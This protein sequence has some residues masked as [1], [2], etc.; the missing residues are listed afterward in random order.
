MLSKHR[1]AIGVMAESLPVPVRVFV[2]E[3]FA[4]RSEAYL[5][6]QEFQCYLVKA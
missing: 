1:I 6:V 5:G 2:L 3:S 4:R